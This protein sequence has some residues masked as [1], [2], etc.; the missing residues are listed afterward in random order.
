MDIY[1]IIKKSDLLLSQNPKLHHTTDNKID[2][3]KTIKIPTYYYLK[4][5]NHTI[6]LIIKYNDYETIQNP[7]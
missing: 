7:R 5:L 1:K 3:Y 2:I 6:P 4:T